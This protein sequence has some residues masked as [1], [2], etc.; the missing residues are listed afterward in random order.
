VGGCGNER[1]AV[2]GKQPF[3]LVA[4][5]SYGDVLPCLCLAR[6]LAREGFP[7]SFA[8]NP[9]F[10]DVVER[11]GIPYVPLGEPGIW[12][13]FCRDPRAW[14]TVYGLQCYL[15]RVIG[16]MVGPVYRLVSRIVEQTPRICVIASLLALGARVAHD[17]RPFRLLTVNPYP[18][19]FQSLRRPPVLPRCTLHNIAKRPAPSRLEALGDALVNR[20]LGSAARNP[21]IVF[22][23][24]AA[25]WKK[26]LAQ[27]TSNRVVDALLGPALA[28]LGRLDCRL[29]GRR[30]FARYAFSPEMTLGLFPDWFAPAQPDW[31]PHVVLSTFPELGALRRPPSARL[32]AF[33]A[34]GPPPV[35]FTFGSHK[36]HSADLFATA[37]A[38]VKRT[39]QRAVFLTQSDQDIP[40]DLPPQVLHS[41]F[42][43]LPYLLR[44]ASLVV[45]HAGIGTCADALRAGLS[46]I[47]V[48]FTYDQP[49]NATRLVRLG[50]GRI[51][52]AG[53]FTPDRL[54]RDMEAALAAP[55]VARACRDLAARLAAEDSDGL[56]LEKVLAWVE[57]RPGEQ[58]QA[59]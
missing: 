32:E 21:R 12:A 35:V 6:L 46:Q 8:A 28:S 59:R 55:D 56:L 41:R 23:K 57:G 20:L 49:D 14:D 7:V 40:D 37:L 54:A 27:Y 1:V 52:P 24:N 43:P 13:G 18:V 10:A 48:P 5:G 45:H 3:L 22:S 4:F 50:V 42:E 34:A 25:S 44:R 51:V 30:I 33:L 26:W 19:F 36:R 17:V 11:L 39:G 2:T 9:E 16:P 53:L 31:P 15:H 38:T 47:L 58:A 29:P